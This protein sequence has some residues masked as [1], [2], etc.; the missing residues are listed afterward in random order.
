MTA[1]TFGNASLALQAAAPLQAPLLRA[2]RACAGRH[3]A[4]ALSPE[5][6]LVALGRPGGD[7][8]TA[9]PGGDS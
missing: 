3:G 4:A 6:A 8:M 9:R 7:S 5:G 1:P 2:V